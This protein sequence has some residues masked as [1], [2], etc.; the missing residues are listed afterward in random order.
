MLQGYVGVP[1]QCPEK[2][3]QD[4]KGNE[5]SSN[6]QFFRGYVSFQFFF[7]YGKNLLPFSHLLFLKLPDFNGSWCKYPCR[8]LSVILIHPGNLLAGT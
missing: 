3:D 7:V 4:L 1:L 2:W 8:D 5:L 6:Q